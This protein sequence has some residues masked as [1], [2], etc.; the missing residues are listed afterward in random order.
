VARPKKAKPSR[1]PKRDKL[2]AL[3]EHVKQ[4]IEA[5]Q[6]QNNG[7]QTAGRSAGRNTGYGGGAAKRT[8]GR[9]R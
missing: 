5:K 4:A 7:K 9:D 3:P 2:Q 6:S 8:G 1:K